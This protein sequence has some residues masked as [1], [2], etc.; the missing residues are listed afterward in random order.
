MELPTVTDD[1]WK[2]FR[3]LKFDKTYVK[4]IIQSLLLTV[5]GI[6]IGIIDFQDFQW[7]TQTIRVV[8]IAI[9]L[10]I[11]YIG[12]VVVY[13][14]FDGYMTRITNATKE[15]QQKIISEMKDEIGKLSNQKE[16]LQSEKNFYS[17]ALLRI[18]AIQ[19]QVSG[20]I[21][22]QIAIHHGSN[23]D[24][25]EIYS[26]IQLSTSMCSVVHQV[27]AKRFGSERD[28]EVTFVRMVPEC[29]A[30]EMVGFANFDSTSPSIFCINRPLIRKKGKQKKYCFENIL[31][32][33]DE[34]DPCILQNKSEI[35]T[36]FYFKNDKAKQNCKYEQYIGIPVYLP[37]STVSIGVLQVVSFRA[38]ALG[39]RK[40]MTELTCDV[41]TPLAYTSLLI[42]QSEKLSNPIPQIGGGDDEN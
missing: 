25:T 21:E 12:S 16:A 22:K 19:S 20:N 28:F 33:N 7:S 29:T 26:C 35:M 38:G 3:Q 17:D 31:M 10:V 5:I 42:A 14:L 18:K 13:E 1:K 23:I 4:I 40:A 30:V 9:V 34:N 41:L 32:D 6:V 8:V 39:S 2:L 15:N 27:L 37:N 11:L 24:K 36:S